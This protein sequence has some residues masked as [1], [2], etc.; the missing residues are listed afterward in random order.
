MAAR[1]GGAG[2]VA[3]VLCVVLAFGVTGCSSDT[4]VADED[5]EQVR[6]Q[7]FAANSLTE[8]MQEATDAYSASHPWVSF[9]D[10]QFLSSGDIG[11]QVTAGAYADVIITASSDTMDVPDSASLIEQDTRFNLF[12]NDLVVAS[13][14]GSGVEIS[15]LEDI[16]TMGYSLSVGDESVPA[17]N[18]ACQALYSIGAYTSSTGR[19]GFFTSIAPMLASSVGNVCKYVEAGEVDLGIVYRSDLYRFSSLAIVY[20]IPSSLHDDIVYPA[21][22]C[23]I[24]NHAED[25]QEFLDW[26]ATDS[27]ALSIWQAWGFDMAS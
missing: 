13:L 11:S 14:A 8:A 18:Y 22:V 9:S 23:S 1:Y 27:E 24:S 25:A 16:A 4:T 2:L 10:T 26:C 17:G 20:Q 3:R 5:R 21:A 12:T 7:I 6:L 15:S 19:G